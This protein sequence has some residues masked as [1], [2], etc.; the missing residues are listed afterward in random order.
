MNLLGLVDRQTRPH[1]MRA[2]LYLG[3]ACV[4]QWET[5]RKRSTPFNLREMPEFNSL[6]HNIFYVVWMLLEE[7]TKGLKELICFNEVD[8]TVCSHIF[9]GLDYYEW[10]IYG[11]SV[12]C[13]FRAIETDFLE[14]W[15]NSSLFNKYPSIPLTYVD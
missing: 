9:M 11:R 14:N 8:I 6:Y 12:V 10:F 3:T 13:A 2:T 4:C 15:W 1:R 5:R 7:G